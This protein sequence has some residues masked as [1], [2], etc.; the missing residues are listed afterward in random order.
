MVLEASNAAFGLN[1]LGGSLSVEMKNGFNYQGA[2]LEVMGGTFGRTMGSAQYGRQ[3]DNVGVY[4][5]MSRAGSGHVGAE[6][7]L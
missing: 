2:E 5:A 1:A 6:R 7:S 3:I 4:V